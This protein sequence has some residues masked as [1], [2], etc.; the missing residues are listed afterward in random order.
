[1]NHIKLIKN[2]YDHAKALA[3]IK[4]LMNKNLVPNSK[5]ADEL[6]VLSL[7]IEHYEQ[8]NFPIEKPDPIDAIKFRMEQLGLLK[9]DLI[10]FIGSASK[11]TEVLNGTRQ[12]SLNM[13]RKLSDGLDISVE[14]L[15]CM[16]KSKVA[17]SAALQKASEHKRSKAA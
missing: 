17:K 14:I 5:E 3:R 16:S 7:L 8:T 4:T 10:P 13:I 6:E 12:L 1:M 11:V 2:K 15:I 9:K